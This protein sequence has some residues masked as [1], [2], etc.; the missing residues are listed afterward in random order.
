M[1]FPRLWKLALVAGLLTGGAIA[2]SESLALALADIQ[3]ELAVRLN[4][5]QS[6]A[7]SNLAAQNLGGA[8][9]GGSAIGKNAAQRA[10]A[11]DPFD[12]QAAAHLGLLLQLDN[13][14]AAAAEMM[15]YAQRVSRRDTATQFWWIEYWAQRGEVAKILRHYDTALRT[16]SQ[17]PSILFP[18]LVTAVEDPIV[19]RQLA[20]SL[21]RNALWTEQFVQQFAQSTPDNAAISRFFLNLAAADFVASELAISTA[22]SRLVE[23][24]SPDQALGIYAAFY[25]E[26]SKSVVRNPS[27]ADATHLPTPFD[28]SLAESGFYV[29][30]GSNGL[31]IDA[32]TSASGPIAS[33]IARL[34]TG[35]WQVQLYHDGGLPESGRL[36]LD[37]VCIDNLIDLQPVIRREGNVLETRVRIPANCGYQKLTVSLRSS[38]ASTA[39][40]LDRIVFNKL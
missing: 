19:S 22:I 16:S 2:S 11:I 18:I 36:T 28:W 34:S 25:P 12:A 31:E 17:A 1:D 5:D 29:G 27:F 24:G 9:G 21:D 8:S 14:Q 38:D 20:E 4:G 13:D 7:L 15:A 6:D 26:V 33:Q 39:L 10:I 3:P 37:L 32:P 35:D 40:K 23:A 30:F